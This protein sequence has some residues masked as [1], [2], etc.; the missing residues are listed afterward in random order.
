MSQ[1]RLH[2]LRFKAMG[3]RCELQ[4][5]GSEHLARTVGEVALA[6]VRRLE[7]KYS[8]Y[9]GDS[10]TSTINLAAGLH[11]VTV[12]HETARLLDYAD[13]LYQQSSG[14]FDVT[15]GILRRAW[16][17]TS[18][19][20]PSEVELTH[21]TPLIGWH[22]VGWDGHQIFLPDPGMELDFGGYVKEYCAD[23][24]ADLCRQ[25][26]ITHGLVNLGGDIHLIGPHPDGSPWLVGI[27]N[28][29][30]PGKP[31]AKVTMTEGAIATSGD[32][33]RYMVVD[34]IRYSHL[35]NPF[36][37][38]SLQPTFAS[39]SVIA[40]RCL[41]A[42]SFSTL[43]LLK[44][45]LEPQWLTDQGLPYLLVDPALRLSGTLQTHGTY[46]TP[47]IGQPS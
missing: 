23:Q 2:S 15:S 43:A 31:I 38:R 25:H 40:A 3:S 26:G 41:I 34:G 8:R 47:A 37:G 10:V 4:L 21:L 39:A 6:Y 12:D 35:L 20:L 19:K 24:V 30:S 33:E 9:R 32:Y 36:T 29:R 18:N 11:P 45:P 44:S 42:G 28:P 46:A 17:F 14:L 7:R 27:Q 1:G 22:R 13:A 5:Y 16:D